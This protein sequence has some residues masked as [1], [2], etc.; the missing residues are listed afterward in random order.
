VTFKFVTTLPPLLYTSVEG[1]MVKKKADS[2][3]MEYKVISDNQAK[4]LDEALDDD[5]TAPKLPRTDGLHLL[6]TEDASPVTDVLTGYEY[7]L[8]SRE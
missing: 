3:V 6:W 7:V 1:V 4:V 8:L 2:S 5:Q